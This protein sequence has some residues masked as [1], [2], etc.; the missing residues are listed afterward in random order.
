MATESAPLI[1]I[2]TTA[3]SA[4]LSGGVV[5]GIITFILNKPRTK[6]EI[7]KMEAETNK[8]RIETDKLR[9]E[10]VGRLKEAEDRLDWTEEAVRKIVAY[11][12]GHFA[13]QT[14]CQI[15]DKADEYYKDSNWHK[16][17]ILL[18]LLD[19]GYLQPPSGTR[20]VLFTEEQE[21]LNK[22]L[23]EIATL[24]PMAKLMLRLRDEVSRVP[25]SE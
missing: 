15:R 12:P 18:L 16:K 23:F 25:S 1:Q 5:A 7:E 11:T 21:K 14:L 9:N 20:E 13:H 3:I 2:I 6:A 22:R 17:R 8:L 10:M 24:T 19:N 4:I